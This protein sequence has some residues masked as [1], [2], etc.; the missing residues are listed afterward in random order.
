MDFEL[1]KLALSELKQ[2]GF[3]TLDLSMWRSASTRTVYE[4][5]TTDYLTKLGKNFIEFC[6]DQE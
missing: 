5:L 3:I 1:L 4:S 2:K 6:L